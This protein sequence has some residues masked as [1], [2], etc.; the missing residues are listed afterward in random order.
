MTD[1]ELLAEYQRRFLVDHDP[2]A[3]ETSDYER[4]KR[5]ATIHACG[6]ATGRRVL[7]LGAANGVLAAELAALATDLVA[8]EGVPAAAHL[9]EARLASHP[10]ARV[11]TGLIPDAVPAGPYDL[12]VASEILYYLQAGAYTQTLAALPRWL[13]TGGRL[14]AVHWRTPGPERPRSAAA[15]HADLE[16]HSALRLV[17]RRDHP[18]YLLSVLE[19]RQAAAD[20]S[21]TWVVVPA[22]DE[23]SRI[24]AALDA[25]GVA[26]ERAEGDVHLVVVDD[27]STDGTSAI[28]AN[29][30]AQWR[31]GDAACLP[32]PA[33]GSGWARR[34]GLD[35]A[36][37]ASHRVRRPDAVVATTDADSRVH[38]DW[39]TALRRLVADGHEVIAGD[40]RLERDA[41][42]RL[43]RA[44]E[45]RLIE[46]LRAVRLGDPAAEHPHF[47]GANLA[48][49][50][51]VLR[52]LTP[53]P[54]PRA[55]EDDALLGRCGALGLPVV[56]DAS[57]P[58]TTS[59]R[60]DGRAELGL[61][62]ALR[63]D[64]RS[65]GLVAPAS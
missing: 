5:R 2:W 65:L 15:V 50:A 9:A 45:A 42:P 40:V 20:P 11:V 19:R 12:V 62:A 16:A 38:P 46:R 32:G 39:F 53:L 1:P 24:G 3:F 25:V 21:P 29:R 33:S 13:A 43:V 60:T 56:R 4:Q 61:A 58:V 17:E 51:A 57:F 31:W 30:M 14:I 7:E 22:R 35:H 48:F 23:E 6:A 52:R 63:D 59:A 18:D 64:A 55:L 10:G 47:A 49:T 26:A 27:G 44:R 8:V 37:R 54:T 36:L 28:V 34:I 41:D